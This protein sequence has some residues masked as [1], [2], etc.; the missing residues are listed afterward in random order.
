MFRVTSLR[1]YMYYLRS[2]I[3]YQNF[4]LSV[5]VFAV[6]LRLQGYQNMIP[7]GG[8]RLGIICCIIP[9]TQRFIFLV[10]TRDI[11]YILHMGDSH[12]LLKNSLVC[13]CMRSESLQKMPRRYGVANTNTLPL[14][15]IFCKLSDSI[16]RHTRLFLSKL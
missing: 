8:F 16:H 11:C 5:Q 9:T 12:N 3:P 6:V 15:F 2:I 10:D 1:L 13:W 14:W 4:G 7:R